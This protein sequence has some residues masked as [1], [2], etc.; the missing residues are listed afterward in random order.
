MTSAEPTGRAR[1]GSGWAQLG[2]RAEPVTELRAVPLRAAAEPPTEQHHLGDRLSAF[3][4]GEL[5]HDAR[6]R[7]QA[8]LATCPDCLA[9]ADES[10]SAKQLLTSSAAPGPSALLMARLLAV[11]ALPEDDEHPGAGGPTVPEVG[12]LGGSRLTG[13]SFGRGAGASFGGGALGAGAPLPGVDPRAR[14]TFRPL[15]AAAAPPVTRSAPLGR[16]FVFAAAGAFSVAAVTLGGVSAVS[17]E[18][19]HGTVTP[20]SGPGGGSVVVPV[21]FPAA[22]PVRTPGGLMAALPSWQP[23]AEADRRPV[24]P[25]HYLR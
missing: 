13:G 20:V 3:V 22:Y 10:R 9:E 8:H 4:D 5:D 16:R 24:A 12:T 25:Q 7:V 21:D 15:A 1:R 11:A 19:Q 18:E 17:G 6:E 23:S 2:R 14:R